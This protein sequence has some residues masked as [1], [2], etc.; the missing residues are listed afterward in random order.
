M[1]ILEN[2]YKNSPQLIFRSFLAVPEFLRRFSALL[3]LLISLQLLIFSSNSVNSVVLEYSSYPIDLGSRICGSIIT[4][5]TEIV[6][7]FI[8]LNDIRL[9]NLALRHEVDRLKSIEA[10]FI[11]LRNENEALRNALKTQSAIRHPSASAKLLSVSMG[12]YSMSAIIAAGSSEGVSEGN[13]VV[14][15][16][17]IIGTI[18]EVSQ[19]HSKI[20]LINDFSSRIPII[21]S[22]SRMRAIL[23][24]SNEG[25]LLL[26]Y[27]TD[28][29][30]PKI[31]EILVSSGDGKNFPEGF[32]LAKITKVS[33]D[34]I[35][36]TPIVDIGRVDFVH[37]L[38]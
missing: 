14:A 32:K 8:D 6:N 24:G 9:K 28:K 27:V 36:A 20:R 30:M 10:D 11:S 4:K 37:I 2:R 18:S 26:L 22:D 1:A 23:A 34:S 7:F 19:H 12:P 31:G 17:A 33:D 21:S 15:D 3:F 35:L 25:T 29:K 16:G 38:K 5:S 13:V